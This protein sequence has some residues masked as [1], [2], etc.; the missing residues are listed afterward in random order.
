MEISV[1][2]PVA[3]MC[4]SIAHQHQKSDRSLLQNNFCDTLTFL[5][6]TANMHDI[7]GNYG[8]LQEISGASASGVVF[9]QTPATHLWHCGGVI[10]S[11]TACI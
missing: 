5:Y 2:T 7:Q 6:N 1:V 11:Q 3:L 4:D 10:W 9:C 8:R